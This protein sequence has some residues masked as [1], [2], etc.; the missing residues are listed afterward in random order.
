MSKATVRL[1]IT[2][3]VQGV[4]FRWFCLREAQALNLTGWVKNRPDGAVECEAHGER[5]LLTTFI[6][7]LEKGPAN[8]HVERVEQNWLEHPG[9][10]SS[11]EIRH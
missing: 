9:Q 10:Y 3:F 4:G 1:V 11:F 6:T 7:S 2:G 8:A 5:N